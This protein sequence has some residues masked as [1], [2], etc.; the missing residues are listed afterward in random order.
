MPS[1][2]ATRGGSA[3][4]LLYAMCR[5]RKGTK[6]MSRMLA[7]LAV[8]VTLFAPVVVF[9]QGA[10][11]C[12]FPGR[13]IGVGGTPGHDGSPGTLPGGGNTGGIF[14]GG[15]CNGNGG[16]GGGGTP[17][18]TVGGGGT[19]GGGGT[20]HATASEPTMIL[21]LAAGLILAGVLRRR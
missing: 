11:D 9:A 18:G 4:S 2:E 6:T 16:N 20:I 3:V 13:G 21:T 8:V 17:G 12:T 15:P 7:A 1:R 5:G 14:P 10:T 19:G